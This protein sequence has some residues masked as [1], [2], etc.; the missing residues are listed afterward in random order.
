MQPVSERIIYV[1]HPGANVN[2]TTDKDNYGLREKVTLKLKVANV[3]NKTSKGM[4]SLSVTD[5]HVVKWNE[6]DGNIKS[7]LLLSP[8]LKGYIEEPG[9]YF[10]SNDS[11]T[12]EN[13]DLLMLTHGWSRFK[14]IDV[15]ANS[16]TIKPSVKDS[17]LYIRGKLYNKNGMPASH[18]SV[19]LFSKTDDNF[20][21]T[22]TT[23]E[24]GTFKFTGLNY[25]DSTLFFIQIKNGKGLNEDVAISIDAMHFPLTEVD[26]AFIPN[27]FNSKGL[28][29]VNYFAHF[30][31][32]SLK[33]KLL[34]EVTVFKTRHKVN[35]NELERV[36]PLSYV[37]SSD[38]IEKYA[39]IN[40][41]DALYSVPGVTISDGHISF[42]GL[43][44]ME[45]YT[46]PLYIV[47]GS[48]FS[49][50]MTSISPYDVDFIEV[51]RGGEAAIYGVRGGNG[52]VIIHTKK[53]KDPT[54]NF[55]QKGIKSFQVPG[56]FVEKEF[57]SPKYETEESRQAKSRDERTTIYWNGNLN[58]DANGT[59]A[60]SF[61]TAD[62]R[63]T[64]T[65]TIEGITQDGK[66]IHQTFSIKRTK[67]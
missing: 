1:N 52:V 50:A 62:T 23:D 8:Y 42:F 49:G 37:I 58:T 46:D 48:E 4:Y 9:Y 32:D 28:S 3:T 64:Y 59:A 16:S 40:L 56:Y 67:L 38:Y 7:Y 31:Y 41:M 66:L 6:N 34:K 19:S 17:S 65:V 57:Y 35:Y 47:N 43:N 14:W 2:L 55:S 22:D 53:W 13:L 33:F 51:L 25:T 63:T 29:G 10:K 18:Y 36:S 54:I 24:K 11:T 27:E 44:S 39:N 61:Y 12:R 15:I 5:D 60:I 21:G 20:I 30:M 45:K 26:R